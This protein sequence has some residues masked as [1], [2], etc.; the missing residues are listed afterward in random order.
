[1]PKAIFYVLNGGYNLFWGEGA[2]QEGASK[3]PPMAC[4]RTLNPCVCLGFPEIRGT[5]KGGYTGVIQGVG[6]RA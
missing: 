1:M 5:F 2:Q 3:V 4:D 6:L